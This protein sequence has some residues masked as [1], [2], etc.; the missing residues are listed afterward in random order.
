MSQECTLKK[1]ST[2]NMYWM[3]DEG[4]ECVYRVCRVP[5]QN[6]FVVEVSECDSEVWVVG[7]KAEQNWVCLQEK[8][9][10]GYRKTAEPLR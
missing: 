1:G 5:K 6:E 10:Q 8:K 4:N 2:V 9:R 3:D 7:G